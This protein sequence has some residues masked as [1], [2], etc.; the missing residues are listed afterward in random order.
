MSGKTVFISVMLVAIMAASAFGDGGG[1]TIIAVDLDRLEP[2]AVLDSTTLT[3]I[4]THTYEVDDTLIPIRGILISDEKMCLIVYDPAQIIFDD[5]LVSLETETTSDDISF[6]S[7]SDHSNGTPVFDL[8]IVDSDGT[9]WR[10]EKDALVDEYV[11]LNE[12]TTLVA[13]ITMDF[14]DDNENVTICQGHRPDEQY[15]KFER[16]EERAN[17]RGLIAFFSA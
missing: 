7:V 2:D 1:P 9:V 11:E 4:A 13:F 16:D 5:T 3:E 8:A 10:F 17:N 6:V 15:A 14:H 12:E